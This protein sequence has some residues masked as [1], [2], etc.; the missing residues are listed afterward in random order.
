MTVLIEKKDK[1]MTIII[2]R[3]DARNAVDAETA[4]ALAEAFR[5]F[6]RDDSVSVA[7]LC[8]SGNTF[9]AGWDLK[10]AATG[11]GLKGV[12]ELRPEDDGP[13]GPT[14]MLLSKPV[15]GAISGHAVAG[16][17]EL[18]LWCDMRVMEEDAVFGVFCRRFGVPLVDGGTV[19]LP[20][21]IGMS[22][23]MDLILT[24][25]PV[26]AVEAKQMGLAN[27]VVQPGESRKASEEL[28]AQIASF[29]QACM[30]SDRMGVY[31]QWDQSLQNALTNEFHRGVAVVETG[32]TLNG[33]DLFSKG[34]G[35]HGEF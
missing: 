27:R 17:M 22:N 8:G 21:L 25:R 28:A 14:K 33:A 3:P 29:P 18:A 15:I 7:V 24:G 1:V 23:A 31:E 20:R 16:G 9:C 34:K 6:E 11:E 35:R 30:R 4:S 19:R 26:D 2:N 13:I 32:E 12:K 10:K 5:K